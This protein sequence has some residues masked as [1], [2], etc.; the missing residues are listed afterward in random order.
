[1]PVGDQYDQWYSSSAV[2]EENNIHLVFSFY[3][4]DHNGSFSDKAAYLISKDSGTSWTT[5]EGSKVKLPLKV[6]SSEKE[7][8]FIYNGRINNKT[9]ATQNMAIDELGNSWVLTVESILS[10]GPKNLFLYALNDK[11]KDP[12]SI[13]PTGA[14][15]ALSITDKGEIIIAYPFRKQIEIMYSND[16][17]KTF[18]KQVI[19]SRDEIEHNIY[20]LSLERRSGFNQVNQPWIIYTDA[21]SDDVDN[22]HV[23][24][25]RLKRK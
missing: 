7:S 18:T 3:Y 1:M 5:Q 15:G 24:A 2:D 20:G 17:G 19:M 14:N 21:T 13:G 8:F 9:V 23:K 12:I 10:G 11:T 16:K 4:E 6:S 22:H 25:I